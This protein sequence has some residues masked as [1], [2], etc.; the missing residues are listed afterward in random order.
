MPCG[1]I[2]LHSDTPHRE[3]CIEQL[4]LI[5]SLSAQH[6]RTDSLSGILCQHLVLSMPS[7]PWF[8]F[9]VI[10]NNVVVISVQPSH[11]SSL[12]YRG[13][14]LKADYIEPHRWQ[15]S[16]TKVRVCGT[17]LRAGP[18][19]QVVSMVFPHSYKFIKPG[20]V[21]SKC[22]KDFADFELNKVP[23]SSVKAP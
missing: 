2:C 15:G 7:L 14:L 1:S 3:P 5:S 21:F 6:I 8:S 4:Y 17:V 11:S 12:F 10:S 9:T 16:C 13:E 23:G 20:T 19:V 22:L 18:A